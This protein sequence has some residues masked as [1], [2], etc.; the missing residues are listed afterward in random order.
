VPFVW[1]VAPL[2]AAACFIVMLGLPR[3]SWIRFG[4]WMVIGIAIYFSYGFWHSRLREPPAP[5]QPSGPG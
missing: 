5:P 3:L 2:G 4:A 1:L